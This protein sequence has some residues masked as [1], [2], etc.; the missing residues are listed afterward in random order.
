MHRHGSR[1]RRALTARCSLVIASSAAASLPCASC[2]LRRCTIATF[3]L[4]TFF[5]RGRAGRRPWGRG[6]QAGAEGRSRGRGGEQQGRT[7]AGQHPGAGRQQPALLERTQPTPRSRGGTGSQRT[8]LAVGLASWGGF[9]A[10]QTRTRRVSLAMTWLWNSGWSSQP[11]VHTC[12][13]EGKGAGHQSGAGAREWRG[14]SAK[15]GSRGERSH[16]V[17]GAGAAQQGR[18]GCRRGEGVAGWLRARGAARPARPGGAPSPA[19]SPS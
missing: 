12:R 10:F 13:H 1:R 11:R 17:G 14:R 7:A 2:T 4:F 19:T 18:R 9:L 6:G 3:T 5:C 8:G 16:S 15:A